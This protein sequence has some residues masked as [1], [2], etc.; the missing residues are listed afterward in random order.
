MNVYEYAAR[1]RQQVANLDA[2]VAAELTD[3]YQQA[4]A[5]I[6]HEL[7][8]LQRDMAA[9]RAAGGEVQAT[10]RWSEWRMRRLLE[11]A[12]EEMRTYA[13][14]AGRVITEAQAAAVTMAGDHAL[15]LLNEVDTRLGAR[16][17]RLPHE[18]FREMV[19][20]TTDGTP[21]M[22]LLAELGPASQNIIKTTLRDATAMGWNPRRTARAMRD[23]FGGNL[24]RAETI[25]R[26][27][28][29]R[30]YRESTRAEYEANNDVVEKWRWSAFHGPRTCAMCLAMDGREFPLGTPMGSHPN[31]RCSMLPVLAPYPVQPGDEPI[32]DMDYGP[33][34]EQWLRDQPIDVQDNVLGP[35]K[36]RAFRSGAMD[37]GDVVGYR[38]DPRWG[39]VRY[40]R[41]ASSL[42]LA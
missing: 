42:K 28:T 17:S 27:E 30:A 25:A 32:P 2:T 20:F 37:L 10:Q 35:T 9:T 19:G 15:D 14:H 16:W 13:V 23:Q 41:S 1:Y 4:Y 22:D 24:A 40:E 11:Q 31:C 18:A 34:G 21:L 5:R 29:M 26:T 36:G 33:T 12:D 39:P 8:V 6:A 38:N 7:E 3:A